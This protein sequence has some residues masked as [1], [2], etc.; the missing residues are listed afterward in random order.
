MST[1]EMQ[2]IINFTL[3]IFENATIT[4][5]KITKSNISVTTYTVCTLYKLFLS[6]P[7]TC[8]RG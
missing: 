8:G 4:V 5:Q 1:Q 7:V 2:I 3:L 6:T